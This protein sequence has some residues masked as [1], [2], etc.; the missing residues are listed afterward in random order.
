MTRSDPAQCCQLR[1]ADAKMHLTAASRRVHSLGHSPSPRG[2]TASVPH[3][4]HSLSVTIRT[5]LH[6]HNHNHYTPVPVS[7]PHGQDAPGP[8]SGFATPAACSL[9]PQHAELAAS[10]RR[11]G[12]SASAAPA[13]G[14]GPGRAGPD[15][16]GRPVKQRRSDGPRRPRALAA[17]PS[18]WLRRCLPSL[19]LRRG[20]ADAA[21]VRQRASAPPGVAAFLVLVGGGS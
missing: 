7:L 11:A 18:T 16:P 15:R 13:G 19:S 12:L 17:V 21:R 8:R 3:Y 14:A 1:R 5:I 6:C 20:D 10:S 2:R 9:R 4:F